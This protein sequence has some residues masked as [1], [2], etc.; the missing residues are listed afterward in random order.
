M[1]LPKGY[2][3]LEYIQSTGTQYVDTLFKPTGATKVV[4]DFKMVNQGTAQQGIFGSRPGSSERFTVFTGTSV[5]RLQV[6]YNTQFGLANSET[7]I[8]GLNVNQRTSLEISNRLVVNGVQIN[9]VTA[10]S[11]T[12][13]YTMYLFANNNAGTAQLPGS[14]FL[15]A[16]QVYDNGTLVRDFI[17]CQNASGAVGLWDDA[18]AEFYGNAGTGA[19]TAGPE[20]V[21]AL[22]PPASVEQVLSVKLAWSAVENA[23]FYR[24]YRDSVQIGETEDLT[25]ADDTAEFGQTYLYGITA[26]SGSSESAPT[27]LTVYT[28]EGYA[29]IRPVVTS[30]NFL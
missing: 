2:K 8:S 26:C 21:I 16:C 7:N 27:E 10:V 18:N 12:S 13:A 24:V 22:D 1:S 15:Y 17:P 23:S 19:F 25:Y 6:D 29:V 14:L 9:E 30:A 20:V 11:F 3:R 5:A 28:R 4:L